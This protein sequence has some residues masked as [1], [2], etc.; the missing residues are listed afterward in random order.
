[1]KKIFIIGMAMALAIGAFAGGFTENFTSNPLTNGWKIFGDTNLFH[2]DATNHNMA[3]TW[4]SSQSNSYF[5][6]PLGLTL[7]SNSDFRI[8]FDLRLKDATNDG[9][10]F[11]LAV[12]LLNFTNA[13]NAGFLRGTGINST[14]VVEFDYFMDPIYGNSLAASEIDTN[15]FFADV[16]DDLPLDTNTTYHIAI[17]HFAG[18]ALVSSQVT[19]SNTVYSE[20]PGAYLESGFGDFNLDTLGIFSYNDT[21]AFA[22]ILAHGTVANISFTTS[23]NPVTRFNGQLAGQS[24][25]TQFQSYSNWV[26]TLERSP[27]LHS[28]TG[29]AGPTNGINDIIALQ[30][31]NA[32]PGKAF[33][34]I[35][36]QK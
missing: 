2:W 10:T 25:Q 28:W 5:Y 15:G 3:V 7:T 32:P 31:T 12:G 29:V 1:M 4:D 11:Q 14:N 19:V 33:Y 35:H 22:S 8:E 34:R 27:D 16:Y 24:W 20:M 9:G 6:R 18:D 17:T 26:Y 23:P 36:A 13:T 21:G 30:D